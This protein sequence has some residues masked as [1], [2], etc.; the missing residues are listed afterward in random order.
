MHEYRESALAVDW[1]LVNSHSITLQPGFE[2]P[3]AGNYS[4]ASA[5]HRVT[6][7]T[8]R[9][10]EAL[11]NSN[12]KFWSRRVPVAAVSQR[13]YIQLVQCICR[14]T[15]YLCIRLCASNSLELIPTQSMQ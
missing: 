12:K 14:S 15:R 13:Q 2:L 10:C 4:T 6:V 8:G 11:L 7:V 9:N 3:N 1:S 5:Q